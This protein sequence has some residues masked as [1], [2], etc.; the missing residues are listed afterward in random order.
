MIFLKRKRLIFWLLRA[1]LRK[2][3]KLIVIFFV[4]GIVL[5]ILLYLNRN[6]ILS[7]IPITDTTSIGIAGTY[8]KQDLPGNLP[9][10]IQ[11]KASRGLTKISPKGEVLPDLAKS[12]E[13][14]DDGKTFIFYLLPNIY[15]ADGKKLDSASINYNFEDVSIER[16]TKEII[17]FKLKDKYS[18]FLVTLAN[19]KVFKKNYVG[20]SDYKISK[21]KSNGGFIDFIEFF[22]EKDK[23]IIKYDF[24]DTQMALKNAFV[25]GEVSEITEINNL[26][27][28]KGHNLTDF[29]N[30]KITQNL[31]NDKI[32]TVFLNN[33]D[34]FL[35]DKKIRK[36]L[37]YSLPN[38]FGGGK[39]VYTPYLPDSW[40]NNK[41]EAYTQDLENAREQLDSSDAS[42]A[43]KIEIELKTLPQYENLAKEIAITW[44]KINLK[45]KIE[46]TDTIPI[47]YQAFL[48]EMP[49]LKDPD[50]YTFWHTGQQNNITRY[51]NLRIDKL[52]EDGRRT[53]NLAERKKIYLDFQKYLID[54]MPAAFLFIPYTYTITRK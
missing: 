18:P 25:L 35:S 15:F 12:W 11:D 47:S 30:V 41:G 42:K 49:I 51:K 20:I 10:I 44:E 3:G 33:S 21:L 45:T 37:G 32:V 7:K 5:A 23:K 40:A 52:L 24:Y 43:G 19:H 39:R 27:Y 14:K 36:A 54:D 53:N 28:K 29:K 46:V 34:P 4:V 50:Q 26:D 48:G 6:F 22:S 9:D 13:I 1:Y 16:P 8:F 2:W 31:N 17:V 38:E